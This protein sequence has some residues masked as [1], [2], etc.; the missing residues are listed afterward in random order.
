MCSSDLGGL[1]ATLGGVVGSVVPGAGTAAGAVVGG[2]AGDWIGRKVADVWGAWFG[3]KEPPKTQA[4]G[5]VSTVSGLVPASQT[6]AAMRDDARK[7]AQALDSQ[8]NLA[9]ALD[10][11]SD[12]RDASTKATQESTVQL[13]KLASGNWLSGIVPTLKSAMSS[14]G[15]A[16]GKVGERVASWI[17]PKTL[18]APS[19]VSHGMPP[20]SPAD[21]Y[22]TDKATRLRAKA[23][24]AVYGATQWASNAM[25]NLGGPA[26]GSLGAAVAAYES[27]KKGY[28]AYNNG[29]AGKG[30]MN[31]NLTDMT[32]GEV[33]ALQ[34]LPKGDSRRVFA[35]GKYQAIPATLAGAVNTLGIDK[36]AKFSP[37]MQDYIFSNYLVGAKRPELEAYIKGKS[38]N[39]ARAEDAIA[40]EF[41]SIKNSRGVGFYDNDKAGNRAVH[42]VSAHIDKA[43][44]DY[45]RLIQEGH[46]EQQAYQLA[47][48][49][50]TAEKA[51]SQAAA[52]A[53]ANTPSKDTANTAN[54][55]SAQ[56]AHPANS[57]LAKDAAGTLAN[58]QSAT[59][60]STLQLAKPATTADSASSEKLNKAIPLAV[61]SQTPEK[62]ANATAQSPSQKVSTQKIV[63]K[64]PEVATQP[65]Q[66]V[67]WQD[68]LLAEIRSLADTIS[69]SGKKE[70]SKD[71]Q[72]AIPTLEN[73]PVQV[74]DLGLVMMNSGVI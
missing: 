31:Y 3:D 45:A 18:H 47:V 11:E 21:E 58:K 59:G 2:I 13:E 37:E 6:P 16:L 30:S 73:V 43:R 35:A 48:M 65:Q 66:D 42:S 68:K 62:M 54:A 7:Q 40:R 56:S 74:S 9:K 55:Q 22:S 5:P 34:A 25:M 27:G 33:M 64:A 57:T 46:S 71:P 26:K 49:G 29:T 69:Q 36:N 14:A 19:L 63:E 8:N 1:G 17:A 4:S 52:Q 51:T 72:Q 61:K 67:S 12:A 24:K 23:A 53:S 20:V 39:K 32:V 60:A 50:K 10:K 41:A 44:E 15:E 70:E 38:A 28:N